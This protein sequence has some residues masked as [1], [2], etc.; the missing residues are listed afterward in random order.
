VAAG[1]VLLSDSDVEVCR[2]CA[3]CFLLQVLGVP[4]DA[5]AAV[6]KSVQ[7]I[8]DW[9]EEASSEEDSEEESDE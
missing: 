2:P 4:A 5:A 6:R 7:A 9:L 8:I 1:E 3:A